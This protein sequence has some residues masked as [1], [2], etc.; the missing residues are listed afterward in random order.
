MKIR[1][2]KFKGSMALALL[3]LSI[4]GAQACGDDTDTE[5]NVIGGA[6]QA[7]GGAGGAHYPHSCRSQKPQVGQWPGATAERVRWNRLAVPVWW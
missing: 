4:V 5:P 1:T 7:R 2:D 6:R 3:A